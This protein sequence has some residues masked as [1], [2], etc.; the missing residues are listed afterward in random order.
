M[1]VIFPHWPKPVLSSMDIFVYYDTQIQNICLK[2][3]L[4]YTFWLNILEVLFVKTFNVDYL[5]I[6]YPLP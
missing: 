3:F 5:K 6:V 1:T 4:K 2:E